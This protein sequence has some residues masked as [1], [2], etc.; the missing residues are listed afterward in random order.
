MRKATTA[1]L[2]TAFSVTAIGI[3]MSLYMANIAA[4]DCVAELQR[5][6][7]TA[8]K[9]TLEFPG[10]SINATTALPNI[11]F[12]AQILGQLINI[13][14]PGTKLTSSITSPALRRTVAQLLE[15]ID[16]NAADKMYESLSE[17]C[18]KYVLKEGLEATISATIFLL[19]A[20][21]FYHYIAGLREMIESISAKLDAI[22]SVALE[23]IPSDLEKGVTPPI[24]YRP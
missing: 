18:Y 6:I 1:G 9:M 16:P 11:T 2:L 23:A 10:I 19:V 24:A 5:Y 3:S 12:P 14:M 15:N 7:A 4:D 21:C 8:S 13:T 20:T 17:F 22:P